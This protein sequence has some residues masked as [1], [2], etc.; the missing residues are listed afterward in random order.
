M[1]CDLSYADREL[2]MQMTLRNKGHVLS[3][4]DNTVRAC[5]A[6]EIHIFVIILGGVS[7]SYIL[8]FRLKIVPRITLDL[9]ISNHISSQHFL[10][11]CSFNL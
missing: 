9:R 1:C 7:N 8:Y 10:I 4:I 5:A 11:I 3:M 6:G 2:M